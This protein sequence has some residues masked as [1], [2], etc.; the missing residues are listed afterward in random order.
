MEIMKI[1]VALIH[2]S[3]HILTYTMCMLRHNRQWIYVKAWFHLF[4]KC[5]S[6]KFFPYATRL[7]NWRYLQKS[8]NI[9]ITYDYYLINVISND[10]YNYNA[11][12]P[13]RVGIPGPCP[14]GTFDSSTL[15]KYKQLVTVTS[16]LYIS[17]LATRWPS[18]RAITEA[19][20]SYIVSEATPLDLD[21]R[22][23][24]AE[25]IFT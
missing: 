4:S 2:S 6:K 13:A 25:M 20:T 1:I 23:W 9:H 3:I 22:V 8:D 16:L 15:C 17:Y 24:L 11:L 19:S 5:N 7:K 10:Y 14:A 12:A 21:W 18:P